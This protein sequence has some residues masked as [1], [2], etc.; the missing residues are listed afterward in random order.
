MFSNHSKVLWYFDVNLTDE[1]LDL[2][3]LYLIFKLHQNAYKER[4]IADYTKC[5]TE[6]LSVLLTEILTVVKDGLQSYSYKVYPTSEINQ[7]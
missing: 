5:T 1:E 6:L 4:Y 7:I 2:P 3:C